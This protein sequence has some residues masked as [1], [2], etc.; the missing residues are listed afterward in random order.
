MAS[1]A[2]NPPL[3]AP[4]VSAA[5]AHPPHGRHVKFDPAGP[6]TAAVMTGGT[7]APSEDGQTLR[8]ELAQPEEA[9]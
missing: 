9:A 2:A 5:P 8:S 7:H 6:A 3:H 4:A 1:F